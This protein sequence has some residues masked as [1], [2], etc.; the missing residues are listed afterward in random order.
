MGTS[1]ASAYPSVPDPEGSRSR[2]IQGSSI[3]GDFRRIQDPVYFDLD[4]VSIWIPKKIFLFLSFKSCAPLG[5][6][7]A[8]PPCHARGSAL[9]EIR[10]DFVHCPY[11]T[12][13]LQISSAHFLIYFNLIEGSKP[14]VVKR[15]ERGFDPSVRFETSKEQKCPKK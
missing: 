11:R 4:P 5:L 14:R 15:P 12:S 2:R 9:L 3:L 6:A 13:L 7:S 1:L 10:E 8:P